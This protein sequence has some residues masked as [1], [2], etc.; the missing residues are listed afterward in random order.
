MLARVAERVYWLARYVERAENTA[1]LLN[2]YS[3]LLLDLPRGTRLGWESLIDIIGNREQF[4][5]HYKEANTQNV[6]RFILNDPRNPSCICNVLAFARENA[7]T[8][9]EVLPSD[10]WEKIN[11]LY[12]RAEDTTGKRLP[13]AIQYQLLRGVIDQAQMLNGMLRG[14]MSRTQAFEFLMI[15][16]FLE[17]ADMT[18]RIV[19]VGTGSLFDPVRPRATA[20]AT[21]DA[22]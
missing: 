10:A 16:R 6:T 3:N 17:R 9:R 5:E 18:T 21:D 13:R 15:G 2:V 14:T 8:T 11:E 19:D 1:R 22:Y 4:F 7:R 12:L 20:V